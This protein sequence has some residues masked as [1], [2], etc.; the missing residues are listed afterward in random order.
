MKAFLVVCIVAVVMVSGSA[1]AEI[2]AEEGQS[3]FDAAFWQIQ[4]LFCLGL[5]A[6]L[7]IKLINRS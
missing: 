2:T 6:G 7:A 1:C 5:T 4:E 3:I